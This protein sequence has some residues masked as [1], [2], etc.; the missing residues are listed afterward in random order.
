MQRSRLTPKYTVNRFIHCSTERNK[1][2]P[3][4]DWWAFLTAA[5]VCAR[6]FNYLPASCCSIKRRDRVMVYLGVSLWGP[7]R[8]RVCFNCTA[9]CNQSVVGFS[10]S[11]TVLCCPCL[12][13]RWLGGEQEENYQENSFFVYYSIQIEEFALWVEIFSWS[14]SHVVS[15][16]SW[17]INQWLHLREYSQCC[18][19]WMSV[20]NQFHWEIF[21]PTRPLHCCSQLLGW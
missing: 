15:S 3:L 16:R 14:E 11:E 2:H 18:S 13:C 20:K 4:G 21:W 10:I 19:N 5:S 7:V 12:Y 8:K 9:F 17:S 1:M 6:K